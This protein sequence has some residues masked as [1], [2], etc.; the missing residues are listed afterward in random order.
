MS[1]GYYILEGHDIVPADQNMRVQWHARR[2][3]DESCWRVA[4]TELLDGVSVST[5]FLGLDHGYGNGPPV[6]FESMVFGGEC[7][8]GCWRYCTW[9]KAEAGHKRIVARL[10]AGLEPNDDD[11]AVP[12]QPGGEA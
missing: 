2:R 6:L 1:D 9:D 11:E 7:D 3:T 12:Q 10:K 4:K 8:G 5:V